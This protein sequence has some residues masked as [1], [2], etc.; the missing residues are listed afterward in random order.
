MKKAILTQR[1]VLLL[2]LIAVGA[3]ALSGAAV[4]AAASSG[5]AATNPGVKVDVSK[6]PAPG[7]GGAADDLSFSG[8]FPNASSDGTGDFRTV[9]MFSHMSF[10]DPIVLPGQPGKSHLHAFAGNL[11]TDANSTADSLSR[12][13]NSTCRGGTVNRSSY[14]QPALI[15]TL[16]GTPIKPDSIIVYYKSGYNQVAAADVRELPSGLRMIAGDPGGNTET[17]WG[18][19]HFSCAGP[20]GETH[21]YQMPADC[22]VGSVVWA[23]VDFPQCWD[24]N[25]LD[26]PD[27][28]S[29]MAYGNT[30]GAAAARG[31]PKL[32]CPLTHPVALPAITINFLY[33]VRDAAALQRWR[34]A[35]DLY[36]AK[37]PAGYSLHADW[38]NGWKPEVV[39]RW[40]KQCINA[41]KDCGAD[42]LGDGWSMSEGKP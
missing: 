27:H 12:T 18:P 40:T 32:G 33:T 36:D 2:P 24:G 10:D 1:G 16:D 3:V 41:A 23:K 17:K 26:S 19:A 9:C 6:I 5:S 28:R 20:K 4:A 25:N 21:G 22:A 39:K 11:L 14:W 29:H 30:D 35:S 42:M 31:G 38:F 8:R 15:D 34:L 37:K 13:G 7:V